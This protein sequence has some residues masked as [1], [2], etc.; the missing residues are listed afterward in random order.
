MI[1]RR[2]ERTAYLAFVIL[3][4]LTI[5]I[6]FAVSRGQD[7]NWDQRNYHIATPYLLAH[8]TF[9]TS[10]V[11][12]GVQTYFNPYVL[13]GEF[14]LL[15]LL[16]AFKAAIAL[17]AFQSLAFMAAGICCALIA[18]D[19]GRRQSF[20]LAA[21]GFILCLLAPMSLSESGTTFIDLVTATPIVAAYAVLLGRG[22]RVGPI[23]SGAVAGGLIGLAIALKL[24]SALFLL[25][26][27]GF[28]LAGPET[29]WT[30]FRMLV[31]GAAGSVAGFGLVGGFWHWALWTRFGNPV[32]PY[33]NNLFRS[34]D[35]PAEP[36]VDARFQAHSI[37]DIWHYPI[38]WILG[39]TNNPELA[40]PSTE[41]PF[42]DLR[43]IL[44]ITGIT[45]L[46]IMLC[47]SRRARARL[48]AAR[49]TGL[50]FA[51]P[52][53]Y[54]AWLF[55]FGIHRYML[56]LDI[57]CGAVILTVSLM[58][59]QAPLRI[60]ILALAAI[61]SYKTMEVADW[62]HLPWRTYWQSINQQPL[63]LDGH[64]LVFLTR[65]PSAYL[66]ASLPTDTIYASMDAFDLAAT[67]NT[68]F[69]RQIRSEL[70]SGQLKHLYVTFQ[71]SLSDAYKQTLLTYG[72]TATDRCRDLP[73]ADTTFRLCE[74][75]HRT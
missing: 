28:A 51:F 53:V 40:T 43:W 9:W 37:L 47:V 15:R 56:P 20:V 71:D 58:I 75:E 35:F 27:A 48:L 7:M 3:A 24:T 59:P 22:G 50:V 5:T 63:D 54:V 31:M 8:G 69:T 62:G 2:A 25:G 67:R 55:M 19:Y 18:R 72:L 74:L 34:P 6:H 66:V 4:S 13:Q 32:F 17:A 21:L 70:A 61:L 33:Y 30:R 36:L 26:I 64:S 46:L 16:P 52:L 41:V 10:S 39:G 60:G 14:L 42:R 23:A 12:S 38:Y 65:A 29:L 11:P 44:A 73:I 1:G 45:V 68:Y 49:S 57:L